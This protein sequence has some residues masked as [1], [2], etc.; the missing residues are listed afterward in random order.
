[1]STLIAV[2]FKDEDRADEFMAEVGKLRQEGLIQL[3]DAATLVRSKAG[4]A[5]IKQARS[6]VGE[7]ALGGAFWGMLIGLLFWVPFLGLAVGAALGAFAGKAA[8]YGISD[9]FIKELGEKV[10]PG[11]SAAFLLVSNAEPEKVV[12]DLKRFHGEI[13]HT[14]LSK[15]QELRLKEAFS[16]AA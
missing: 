14:S 2:A 6:L 12:D 9:D 3:E 13:L 1:M 5:R 8:D 16:G 10:Q 7:G 11:N 4:K 15:E